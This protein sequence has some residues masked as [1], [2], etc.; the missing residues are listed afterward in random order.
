[1]E[2]FQ[3]EQTRALR[4]VPHAFTPE[5]LKAI[6]GDAIVEFCEDL[7]PIPVEVVDEGLIVVINNLLST[8]HIFLPCIV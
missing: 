4:I 3:S 2:I 8:K 7:T 1:M 5:L 6:A